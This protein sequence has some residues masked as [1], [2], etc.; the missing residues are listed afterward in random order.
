MIPRLVV[1]RQCL[2]KLVADGT[3]ALVP[4]RRLYTRAN[5][6]RHIL[7]VQT[8]PAVTKNVGLHAMLHGLCNTARHHLSGAF[9][10]ALLP[11][12]E[13]SLALIREFRGL[14]GLDVR[15]VRVEP[16]GDE[17]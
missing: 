4:L 12:T 17:L 6:G 13:A 2:H 5:A 8:D 3:D 10:V 7:F 9:Q 14:V 11:G 15:A 16:V 1:S